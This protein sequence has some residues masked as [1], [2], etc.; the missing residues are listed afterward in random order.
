MAFKS[1]ERL[2][3][4]GI[5]ETDC[6]VMA[7]RSDT[8]A[9]WT[10]AYFVDLTPV[11]ITG[12]IA[13]PKLPASQLPLEIPMVLRNFVQEFAGFCDP[14]QRPTERQRESS[15]TERLSL[16]LCHVLAVL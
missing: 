5:P 15:S 4:A 11:T 8:S 7:T 13:A 6:S 16:R 9:I 1:P 3:G 2:T 12:P 14:A 10:E